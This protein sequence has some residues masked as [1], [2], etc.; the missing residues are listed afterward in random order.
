MAGRQVTVRK[1]RVIKPV[2]GSGLRRKV[3]CDLRFMGNI[4]NKR[5]KAAIALPTTD[6]GR[7]YEPLDGAFNRKKTY[8]AATNKTIVK[9][10]FI[11]SLRLTDDSSLKIVDD[12]DAEITTATLDFTFSFEIE[13]DDEIASTG[14]VG[15][16]VDDFDPCDH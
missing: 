13:D 7:S 8:D 16:E 12:G 14:T 11:R 2:A 4:E 5:I 1:A 3:V 10:I 9:I 15:V 6:P